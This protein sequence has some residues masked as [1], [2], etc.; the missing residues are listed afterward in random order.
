MRESD[1][2]RASDKENALV[3]F[4]AFALFACVRACA[5]VLLRFRARAIMGACDFAILR[6]CVRA[7]VRH[8]EIF[9]C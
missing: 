4:C 7:C 3:R 1:V 9:S 6:A 5:F 8:S 2:E